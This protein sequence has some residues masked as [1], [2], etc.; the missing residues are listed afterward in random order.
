MMYDVAELSTLRE[1]KSI[2]NAEEEIRVISKEEAAVWKCN[3]RTQSVRLYLMMVPT[4]R[5]TLVPR[6]T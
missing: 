3:G 2:A 4:N 1:A 5:F 6:L